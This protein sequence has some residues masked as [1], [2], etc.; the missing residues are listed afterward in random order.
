[1]DLPNA[2]NA[3]PSATAL[4]RL[5][6]EAKGIIIGD[7]TKEWV[8]SEDG[9]V[10]NL[11][12]AFVSLRRLK[13]ELEEVDKAFS[14]LFEPAKTETMPAAFERSGVPSVNLDEGY[15][16]TI[17][18]DV[19]ASIRGGE[20][21]AAVAWLRGHGLGSLVQDTVNASTLSAAARDMMEEGHELPEAHFN[22]HNLA[23]T[24][25]TKR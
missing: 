15:R 16:V 19:R 24:S 10:V 7:L 13:D 25:V 17:R 4:A 18:H 3:L 8:A 9:D 2:T 20:R 5:L 1:M 23:N 14:K 21:D 6:D 11:A 12:R 22:V